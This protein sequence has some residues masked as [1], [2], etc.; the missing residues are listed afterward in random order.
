MGTGD[1]GEQGR[2]SERTGP[3]MG[4]A[5]S[6][7]QARTS[8]RGGREILKEISVE[9]ARTSDVVSM[10]TPR[11]TFMAPERISGKAGSMIR[12]N[13]DESP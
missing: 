12:M 10:R 1:T 4:E 5:V 8:E 3:Q 9:R 7:V 13:R 11:A 6:R 2:T